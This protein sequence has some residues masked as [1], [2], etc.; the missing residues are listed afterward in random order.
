MKIGITGSTGVLGSILSKKLKEKNYKISVFNSDIVNASK[1]DMWIKKNNFDFIFHLA[2]IVPVKVC[3]ENPLMACSVNIGGT[4]NI[5]EALVKF[6]KKPWLFYAS[7]SHVYKAK[8]KPLLETDP[9]SPKTFYGYTKWVG[10][11]ILENFSIKHNLSYCCGRIFS[12]YDD[13]QSKNFLFPS[14]KDKIKRLQKN[15]NINIVNA[16]SVIDIQKATNVVKIILKLFEK[17]A[18]G[19][20]NIGTGKGISVKNFARSL[21][22]KKIKICT[23]TKK[24]TVIVA[25]IKKLNSILNR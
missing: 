13:F 6:K 2:A 15:N 7:T 18:Q 24:K 16:H 20:F 1:V 11:K 5:L 25:D 8:N 21:T 22:K 12:F 4:F 3:N 9:I 19:I 17:K 23:N 10:E 14:I